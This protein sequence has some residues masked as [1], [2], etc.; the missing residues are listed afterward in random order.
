MKKLVCKIIYTP[1]LSGH[2][3]EIIGE[4]DKMHLFSP[5]YEWIVVE[6]KRYL[7]KEQYSNRTF[8]D[9][10][11]ILDIIVFKKK[12]RYILNKDTLTWNSHVKSFIKI[13]T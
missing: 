4:V 10:K 2:V 11:E 9:K 8:I 7:H 5:D 12:I 13:I 3:I 6:H 1:A